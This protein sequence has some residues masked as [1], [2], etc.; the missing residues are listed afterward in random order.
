MLFGS[1]SVYNKNSEDR[2]LPIRSG[3]EYSKGQVAGLT[4]WFSSS[5]SD[6]FIVCC[7][8]VWH[9]ILDFSTNDANVMSGTLLILQL[10]VLSKPT[11]AV[12]PTISSHVV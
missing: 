9:L 7:K 12:I 3:H 11:S 8:T 10:K 6:E 4:P 5:V 2:K 1:E